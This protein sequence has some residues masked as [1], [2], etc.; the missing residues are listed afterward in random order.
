[1]T[2]KSIDLS[3]VGDPFGDFD[4]CVCKNDGKTDCLDGDIGNNVINHLESRG[5][6]INKL[7]QPGRPAKE[8]IHRV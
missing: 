4:E 2:A 8:A 7:N 5:S 3:L 1:V 6:K